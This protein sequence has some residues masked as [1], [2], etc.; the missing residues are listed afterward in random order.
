MIDFKDPK[1]G[2]SGINATYKREKVKYEEV[3]SDLKTQ[4]GYQ[5][6][7]SRNKVNYFPLWGFVNGS[8]QMDLMFPPAYKGVKIILCCIDINTRYAYAYCFR[9]KEQTHEYIKQFLVDAEKDKREVNYIQ[10]DRGSEFTNNKVSDILGEIEHRFVIKGDKAAQAIVERFNGTLRR[11]ISNYISANND[12]DWVKVFDDLLY[13]YNHR[14][15]TGIEGTPAEATY[16][17]SLARQVKQYKRAKKDFNRF[18]VGDSVRTLKNKNLFDKG[19][20]TWSD[21]VYK[22]VGIKG[23]KFIL[24]DDNLYRHYEV[25][26]VGRE[27]KDAKDDYE[28]QAIADK[29]A[30][31]IIRALN[32]EGILDGVNQVELRTRSKREKTVWD[33]SLVGRRV[34]KGKR[35]G[36]I[37]KYDDE[38]PYHY[39]VEFDNGDSEFMNRKELILYMIPN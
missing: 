23:H 22:I 32:K 13:N 30:K 24:D 18:S 31:K 11:L 26:K 17:S 8:W 16:E 39:F 36:K 29:K 19:R 38:G 14:Y 5:L 20:Q 25:Q 9:T 12:N 3:S 34:K 7:Y 10:M 4:E 6:N 1:R 37:T 33:A 15:H 35:E 2:L 21:K 28:K 27:A